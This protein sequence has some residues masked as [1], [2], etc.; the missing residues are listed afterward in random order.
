VALTGRDRLIVALDVPTAAEAVAAVDRLDNVSFFKV[1][2]QV[3]MSSVLS[4]DFRLLLE[5]LADKQVFL[6]LK[7][8]GDID[9]TVGAVVE[10]C[11]GLKNVTFLTLSDSMP[12]RSIRAAASARDARRS[13]TPKLLT[14]P[15]LSS[16]DASDLG[17]IAGPGVTVEEYILTRAR[18]ALGAGCDGV[19]VSGA[20]IRTCREGLGPQVPLVT[21]GVRPAGSAGDDQKRVTTPG[22]AIRFGADYLVVGRPIMKSAD[23]RAAASR[24]IEEIDAALTPR[25]VVSG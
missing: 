13:P 8:P 20:A 5:R 18:T 9:N 7:I 3:F 12:A 4:G 1:G 15:L 19:I 2:W 6:D 24:V 16:L 11:A 25:V 17:A 21:P 14:V 23:P 22:E 10:L